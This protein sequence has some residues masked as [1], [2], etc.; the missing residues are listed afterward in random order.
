MDI[1]FTPSVQVLVA[2]D[3]SVLKG[4]KKNLLKNV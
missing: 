3:Y 2:K 1:F 4:V